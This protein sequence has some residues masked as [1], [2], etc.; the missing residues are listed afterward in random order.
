MTESDVRGGGGAKVTKSDKRGWGSNLDFSS[1]VIYEWPQRLCASHDY[2]ERLILECLFSVKIN[3][4]KTACAFFFVNFKLAFKT[5]VTCPSV[6]VTCPLLTAPFK[7]L[8][9]P[10]RN[11]LPGQ[12]RLAKNMGVRQKLNL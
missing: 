3:H 5:E 12:V 2:L 1:D 4:K 10:E 7:K 8:H 11:F 9:A 6:K